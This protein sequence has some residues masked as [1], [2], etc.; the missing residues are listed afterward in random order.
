MRSS[1]RLVHPKANPG[2]I[3]K[4]KS[5]PI[6]SCTGGMPW[7][8]AHVLNVVFW[9]EAF[10]CHSTVPALAASSCSLSAPLQ[11]KQE[12]RRY[13]LHEAEVKQEWGHD[14]TVRPIP[15]S[16]PNLQRD[17]VKHLSFRVM[18]ELLLCTFTGVGQLFLSDVRVL[19][20]KYSNLRVEKFD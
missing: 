10:S 18:I 3:K 17:I 7:S 13:L 20:L 12:V 15:L 6:I 2:Y 8:S 14:V 9:K 16:S 5:N 19:V 11:L 4:A 1:H